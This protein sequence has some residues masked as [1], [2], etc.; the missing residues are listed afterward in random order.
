M[1][2][3]LVALR[4]GAAFEI[5]DIGALVGDEE[6]AFE[7]AALRRVDA[8]IGA[9]L[10]RRAHP[11]RDVGERAVAEHRRI[12]GRKEIIVLR[13]HGAEIAAHQVGMLAH[14]LAERAE[15]DAELGQMALEGRRHR[16]AVEH[17]IDRHVPGRDPGQRLA[18]AHRH[19]ELVVH[20][21]QLGIDL[22]ERFG[23]VVLTLG[24]RPIGRALVVDRRDVELGP[25]RRLHLLP[26][27]ERLQPPVEQPFRLAFLGRDVAHRVL[28]EAGRRGLGLDLGDETVFV[29]LVEGGDLGIER[30]AH[31]ARLN[32]APEARRSRWRAGRHR[33]RS[34]RRASPPT[35]PRRRHG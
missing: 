34:S 30:G 7:L 13:H 3:V 31:R 33:A 9:E 11:R 23:R 25:I 16:D 27:A 19:A 8:E 22:V 24:C 20:R 18:L 28:I 17:R 35:A 4:R 6:R 12:Q 5:A 15:D 29:A 14:R 10:H 32:H 2:L 1:E 21:Q 26:G